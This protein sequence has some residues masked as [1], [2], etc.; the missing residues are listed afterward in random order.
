MIFDIAV[1]MVKKA[2]KIEYKYIT[3]YLF[4]KASDIPFTAWRIPHSHC[5]ALVFAIIFMFHTMSTK[6][7][8]RGT[9]SLERLRDEYTID[10]MMRS[11]EMGC[12]KGDMCL[13]CSLLCISND[14]SGVLC[15][16][17]SH[18]VHLNICLRNQ[19]GDKTSIYF[20]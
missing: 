17:S 12:C 7:G 18:F 5:I 19:R 9:I 16:L 14:F 10:H 1:K 20:S 13:G 6:V 8:Q 11:F 3:F 15:T 2:T 4:T